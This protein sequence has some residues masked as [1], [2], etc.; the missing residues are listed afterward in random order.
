MPAGRRWG[1]NAAL[2]RRRGQAC[3][4]GRTG[5][6]AGFGRF[7]AVFG[8]PADFCRFL[9]GR[10]MPGPEWRQGGMARGRLRF[11]R[12]PSG[13]GDSDVA[14]TTEPTEAGGSAGS[15]DDNGS[16]S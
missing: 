1:L 8:R 7:L 14:P 13:S 2:R 6:P 16:H 5:R 9:A 3:R 12:H 10:R 11:R 4:P 15:A